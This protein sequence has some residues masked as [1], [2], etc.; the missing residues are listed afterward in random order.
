MHTKLLEQ[1]KLNSHLFELNDIQLSD[2]I[3]KHSAWLFKKIYSIPYHD[4][5]FYQLIHG[6]QNIARFYHG[7]QHV[8]RVAQYIPVFANL[9]RRYHDQEALLLTQED[10]H[11]LQ[12]AALFHDAGREGEGEDL[13]DK[14]SAALFYYYSTHILHVEKEKAKLFAEAIA[15]KDSSDEGYF[16]CI[17]TNDEIIWQVTHDENKTKQKNIYQK[18][19]HDADCLDIIRARDHFDASHL[20]FYQTIVKRELENNPDA[21]CFEEMALLITE[22]RSIIETQGDSRGCAQA[23]IKE[24]FETENGYALSE[25][26]LAQF[27][28]CIIP[29]LYHQ[30]ELL[31][32]EELNKKILPECPVFDPNKG[33]TEENMRA[34][35]YGK[36]ADLTARC[37]DAPSGIRKKD[38]ESSATLEI[39]K[40]LRR[41]G[42]PTRAKKL[43][44]HGNPYRSVSRFCYGAQPYKDCGFLI[45]NPQYED[46]ND[47]SDTD[48]DSGRF[49][50]LFY[51]K[52]SLSHDEKKAAM[53]QLL[54]KQKMGG[55]SRHFD[56]DNYSDKHN[57][58]IYC[59]KNADAVFFT[60]DPTCPNQRFLHRNAPL[61]KAIYLQKEYQ[62]QAGREL[63]LFEYSGMHHYIKLVAALSK[64][65]ILAKWVA[66]CGDYIKKLL[67]E[68]KNPNEILAMSIEDI[69]V[70]AMYGQLETDLGEDV[71]LKNIP[72]DANYENDFKNEIQN[73][74]E[75][76]RKKIIADYPQNLL[77]KIEKKKLSLLSEQVFFALLH[78]PLLRDQLHEKMDAE[79][80]N[81]ATPEWFK[82]DLKPLFEEFKRISEYDIPC[83]EKFY[84]QSKLMKYYISCQ[85]NHHLEKVNA[86][87]SQMKIILEQM[88]AEAPKKYSSWLNISDVI[89]APILIS[90]FFGLYDE[91]AAK[92]NTALFSIFDSI[93]KE[94]E[95]YDFQLILSFLDKAGLLK[96][97]K[98]LL[99]KCVETF[100]SFKKIKD[101]IAFD[102]RCRFAYVQEIFSNPH[103]KNTLDIEIN[104]F[105]SIFNNESQKKADE[106]TGNN[107]EKIPKLNDNKTLFFKTS[108]H[109]LENNPHRESSKAQC[110]IL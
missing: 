96:K 86:I 69:K 53:H 105:N 4:H 50:K 77:Q 103:S 29:T 14:D 32:A 33:A 88:I 82:N 67:H 24:K 93:L 49:K 68:A 13:W 79:L 44:A 73:A 40:M 52:K 34:A 84:C 42:E 47:I 91:Y 20:D 1:K 56:D 92:I 101:Q 62:N 65:D 99:A 22:A 7:I 25:Q 59:M 10:I 72:A 2:P 95:I 66:L 90:L 51:M 54:L 87:K 16:E 106:I 46:I 102:C 28:H 11:L 27:E 6:S 104:L 26:T 18:L 78:F 81:V 108:A 55:S 76:E 89:K 110:N 60:L 100:E 8:N 94:K 83:F 3:S 71:V 21:L 31:A 61:L 45:M 30:G 23:K 19:I 43:N 12:I 64:K 37:I 38:Q 74:I 80:E 58:I 15:N 107:K 41:P 57:E 5:A 85:L 35:M 109:G 98:K 39:R 70:L 17:E 63:P 75:A 9:Y 97:N 36:N 48:I